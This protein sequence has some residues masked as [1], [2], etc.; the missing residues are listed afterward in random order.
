MT[1]F[2][3]LY[4]F[5]NIIKKLVLYKTQTIFYGNMGLPSLVYY[6]IGGKKFSFPT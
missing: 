5:C 1:W 3:F 4:Q 6:K 2:D